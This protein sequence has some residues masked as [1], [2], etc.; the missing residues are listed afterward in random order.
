LDLLNPYYDER[1]KKFE[2]LKQL[3]QKFAKEKEKY[4][5]SMK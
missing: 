4:L 3:T 1:K 5:Q 2:K